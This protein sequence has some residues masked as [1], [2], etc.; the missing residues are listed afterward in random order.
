VNNDVRAFIG[1]CS[2]PRFTDDEKAF[3]ARW[4]P[5]GLIVFGRNIVDRPQVAAL[6]A[7]F[8]ATVGRPD[9]PVLV[10]Q[11]GGRVQRLTGPHWP[12]YPAASAFGGAD[13][14]PATQ[15][16]LAFLSARLMA[17]DLAEVGISVDCLPVLDVPVAGSHS[18]IGNR[19]Y[20]STAKRVARL[21]RAAAEGLMAGGVLP[22][23]KHVPGHG[24]AFADSHIQ[25]PLVGASLAELEAEDFVPFR[26][27]ADLPAAMTA[28][29]VYSA[30]DPAR[31]ATLSPLVV[32]QIIRKR[33]GFDGLL[34]SDDLAM[35]ALRGTFA[36]RA[37][38]I[39]EAGL[40]IALHCKPWGMAE[41]AAVAPRLEGKALERA[42]RALAVTRKP[43]TAF[44]P[45]EARAELDAGLAGFLAARA[46]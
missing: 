34:M 38:A 29:V 39:F 9:A 14:S 21:G 13:C 27:N 42:E 45:V 43:L 17:H 15:E 3:F 37:T 6:V 10:D 18:V 8:R 33:I 11:E 26:A 44:D 32:E 5:W 4:Q 12:V 20:A 28:H 7:E 31:P 41:V 46:S 40:D 36:A 19:A 25:L 23:M 30:L 35:K 2:G 24:R 1:A 16:R 22:V